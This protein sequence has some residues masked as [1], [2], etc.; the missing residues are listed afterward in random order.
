MARLPI[1]NTFIFFSEGTKYLLIY[2]GFKE[3]QI[4]ATKAGHFIQFAW[5]KADSLF[6]FQHAWLEYTNFA[7]HVSVLLGSEV[8]V[9]ERRFAS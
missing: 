4:L 2:F 5:K 6:L 9:L 3:K 8:K 1:V 7:S